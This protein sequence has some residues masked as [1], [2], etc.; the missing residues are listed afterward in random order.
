MTQ[1]WYATRE[2]VKEVLDFKET[3]RNNRRIDRAISTAARSLERQMHRRFYPEDDTRF[4]DWPNDQFAPSGVLYLGENRELISLIILKSGTTVI[5]STDYYLEPDED[6]PPFTRLRLRSDKSSSFGQGSTHQR[7]VTMTGLFGYQND[8]E[9]AGTINEALDAVETEV[10]VT[11]SS[12]IGVGSLIKVDSERMNVIGKTY[13]ASGDTVQTDALI[14]K[15]DN[16]TVKVT[17][18]STFFVDEIILIDAEK[19]KI[20]EI[21]T[22]SLIVKRAW[23][24]TVLASHTVST[25]VNV[26]RRL[27]VEREVLGSTAATHTTATPIQRFLFP[28]LVVEY[29]TALALTTVLQGQSGY[30]RISG[31][32]NYNLRNVSQRDAIGR[33]V[34]DIM[35]ECYVA[36]GRKSRKDAI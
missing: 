26:P 29:C 16:T 2:D 6:G 3:A 1:I 36:H 8:E 11:D 32:R 33:G 20:V 24:G 14:A 34:A 9:A 22:N 19:M 5:P 23:D 17:N 7:D 12:E 25:A 15:A 28:P 10:D 13:I 31:L 35:E 18:G 21:S 27:V 4:M 30:A